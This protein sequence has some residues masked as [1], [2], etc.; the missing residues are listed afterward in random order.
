MKREPVLQPTWVTRCSGLGY[1]VLGLIIK[2]HT[3][4]LASGSYHAGW[5]GGRE[6]RFGAFGTNNL[7]SVTFV[8]R[9]VPHPFFT[10][11]PGADCADVRVW[12]ALTP[13]QHDQGA[14][15]SIPSLSGGGLETPYHFVSF[16]PCIFSHLPLY[17]YVQSGP[18]LGD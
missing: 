3:R 16:H 9:E 6:I 11:M 15:I 17:T 8:I 10:R 4:H 7:Q 5:R 14:V 2:V 18:G 12:C 13:A 1:G